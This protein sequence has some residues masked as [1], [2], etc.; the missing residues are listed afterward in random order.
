MRSEQWMPTAILGKIDDDELLDIIYLNVGED[1]LGQLNIHYQNAESGF[2]DKPDWLGS[3]NTDGNLQLVDMNQDQRMDLLRLNGEG[4]DSDARFFLNRE[5][6]FNLDQPD[7]IMR[8]SGYDVQLNFINLHPESSPVLNVSYYTIP[9]VDAIRN[10]SIHR[11]QLMYGSENAEP[12]QVVNRRPDSSLEESF[13][14][15][16]VRS[17]VQQM[18]L[19]YDVDGDGSRD[20]MYI[21]EN[22][23]LA[24]KRIE[25][26]LGIADEPFWEYVSARSVFEFEV[27]ALNEDSHPDLILRHGTSTTILVAAP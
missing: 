16:N 1:G 2:N 8:F 22:G 27:L 7:Q 3:L 5:G 23:T 15:A 6:G 12:G 20:A 24:A 18:S 21:T 10:A 14:A 11:T 19:Q 26:D 9:V 13:S 17:L 25:S 4:N